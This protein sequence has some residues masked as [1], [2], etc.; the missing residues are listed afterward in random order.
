MIV[1][2]LCAGVSEDLL[3][4]RHYFPFLRLLA[5]VRRDTVNLLRVEDC[6]DA[7][8]RPAP[9]TGA[10]WLARC[11]VARRLFACLIVELPEFDLRATLALSNLPTVL[12]RL[13]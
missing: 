11:L 5:F 8:D 13:R 10:T 3:T 12:L 9:I 1:G 6:V 2:N 4:C 7:M